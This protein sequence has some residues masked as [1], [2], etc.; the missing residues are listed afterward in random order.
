MQSPRPPKPGPS[1][2]TEIVVCQAGLFFSWFQWLH[3]EFADDSYILLNMDETSVQHEYVQK[4]GMVVQDAPQRRAAGDGFFMPMK[5]AGTRSH[6]TMVAFICNNDFMQPHLP[7]FVL[8]NKNIM[9]MQDWAA[10]GALPF[11]VHVMKESNGWVDAD[12]MMRMLTIVRRSIRQFFPSTPIVLLLD[13]ASQHLSNAVLAKARMLN[14]ILLLVPGQLTWL[15]QP[16]DV[17][18]F[19]TF[20]EVLRTL[21]FHAREEHEAG[22]LPVTQ[23]V[24]ALQAAIEQVLINGAFAQVFEKCGYTDHNRILHKKIKQY[25]AA[26]HEAPPRIMTDAEMVNLIGRNRLKMSEK[27]FATPKRLAEYR[28]NERLAREQEQR[29]VAEEEHNIMSEIDSMMTDPMLE[30]LAESVAS[31]GG[32]DVML[33]QASEP[34]APAS[35]SSSSS[36]PTPKAQPKPKPAPKATSVSH[37]AGNTR[38]AKKAKHQ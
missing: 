22:L 30:S 1:N 28:A 34:V 16:L 26:P 23:R 38:A 37:I 8:P 9:T 21:Q 12:I 18:V 27:F 31:H 15:L 4:K 13:S 5:I 20:K 7:Q 10:Y 19:R 3:K 36:A 25:I 35:S 24:A 29:R 2:A 33:H 17:E 14:V 11:P 32:Q 6:T